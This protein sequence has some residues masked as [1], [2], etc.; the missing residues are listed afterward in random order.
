MD[1]LW[2]VFETKFLEVA[3]R[4]CPL[5]QKKV[6]G[7]DNCPWMTGNIKKDIPQR[8]YLLKKARKKSP[9]EDWLSLLNLLFL[10][11]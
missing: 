7:M 10:Y 5:I 8:D 4:H 11:F 9:D 6:R 1:E 2:T 3:D